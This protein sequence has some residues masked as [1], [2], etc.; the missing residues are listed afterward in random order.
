MADPRLETDMA[1]TLALA[2]KRASPGGQ[3]RCLRVVPSGCQFLAGKERPPY[4]RSS[5]AAARVALSAA[6]QIR[7]TQ[8][9]ADDRSGAL[10]LL[11][12]QEAGV[13]PA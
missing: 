4:R 9:R 7:P 8:Q 5:G 2:A 1:L 13:S 11:L 10:G 3:P 6:A 12:C